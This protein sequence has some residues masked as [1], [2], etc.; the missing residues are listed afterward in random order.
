MKWMPTST[1]FSKH[2]SAA[3]TPTPPPYFSSEPRPTT[4]TFRSLSPSCLYSMEGIL[5]STVSA[6]DAIARLYD[7]WSRSVVEDVAFYVE[8]AVESGGP[9]VELG[10][11]TGRIAVAVASAGVRVIGVDS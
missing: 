3:W 8:I 7:P 6:Y 2:A 11:G 1:A 9:V 10:V 4:E 5:T